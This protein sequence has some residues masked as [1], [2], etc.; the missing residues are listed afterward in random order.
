MRLLIT[1]LSLLL[2]TPAHAS[3]GDAYYNSTAASRVNAAV[4]LIQANDFILGADSHGEGLEKTYAQRSQ[5]INGH[6][7][8]ILGSAGATWQTFR[9]CFPW[10]AIG[11]KSPSSIHLQ[12]SVNDAVSGQCCSNGYGTLSYAYTIMQAV[13]NAHGALSN[14]KWPSVGTDPPPESAV[15]I[16][17]LTLQSASR[18][19]FYVAQNSGTP[20]NCGSA[21][22]CRWAQDFGWTGAL[23]PQNVTS[24]GGS[25]TFVDQYYLMRMSTCE[26]SSVPWNGHSCYATVGSTLDNVHFP[27]DGNATMLTNMN[28]LP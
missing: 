17:G 8:V 14:G 12:S 19:V 7:V 20:A 13:V 4:A 2:L 23:P 26:A 28:G 25:L 10:S 15:G 18:M 1:L 16:D 9:D 24:I 11:A 3:C 6:P 21:G 22:T 27:H 5:Y